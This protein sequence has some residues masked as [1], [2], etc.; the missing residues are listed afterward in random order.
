MVIAAFYLWLCVF[1]NSLESQIFLFI[2]AIIYSPS[3]YLFAEYVCYNINVKVEIDE[4]NNIYYINKDI[5][6]KILFEN[7]KD[8]ELWEYPTISMLHTFYFVR[9]QLKSGEQIVLTSLLLMLNRKEIEQNGFLGSLR[10]KITLYPSIILIN[11]L[12][13]KFNPWWQSLPK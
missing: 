4:N 10:R 12:I 11:W 5:H 7:I 3:L 1:T 9:I 8:V 6:T 2:I 13:N